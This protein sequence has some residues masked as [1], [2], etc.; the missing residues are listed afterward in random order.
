MSP[1]VVVAAALVQLVVQAPEPGDAA[2]AD[3]DVAE[4]ATEP[5]AP[6]TSAPAASTGPA[7]TAAVGV[8]EDEATDPMV[9]P[10]PRKFSRGF[11]AE[12]GVGPGIPIG[13]TRRVL[14]TAFSFS[15]RLGYEIRRWVA[16]DLHA[17][18]LLSRYDDGVLKRELFMQGVYTGEARLG[19]PFRRFLVAAHG[20]AGVYQS[21]NNL[22]QIADVAKNNIRVGMA[23]DAG[24]SFDVHS[25]SRHFSGGIAATFIGTPQLRNAGTL[26]VQIYVRYSAGTRRQ[27]RGVVGEPTR[28]KRRRG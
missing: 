11:F 10:D 26:L 9:F 7:D 24:L 8:V 2:A 14:S 27:N 15:A 19:V 13:P 23:W 12:I 18:G 28:K 21:S 25:L 16:I 5:A 17:T 1:L 4:A 20:G 3:A 6:A 22:L